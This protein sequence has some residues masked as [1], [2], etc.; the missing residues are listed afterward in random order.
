MAEKQQ[1]RKNLS[2]ADKVKYLEKQGV[3]FSNLGQPKMQYKLDLGAIVYPR[4][5]FL[6]KCGIISRV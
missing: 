4:K 1:K 6:R 5:E 2:L 3:L